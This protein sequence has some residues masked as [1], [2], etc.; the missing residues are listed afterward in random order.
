MTI[1]YT[2]GL[3]RLV[4]D[5]R[6]FFGAH[7][8]TAVVAFGRKEL[9]KQLNQGPG[10]ANRV[11]I[12][13]FDPGSGAG[14][15]LVHPTLGGL[16]DVYQT[17]PEPADVRVGV[18]RALFDWEREMVVSVWA[19]DNTAPEDELAQETALQFLVEKTI[20]AVHE[21]AKAAAE[22]GGISV[23]VPKGERTFGLEARIGLRFTHPLYDVPEDVGYPGF[24]L[25]R[26]V[27]D[28]E[29]DEEG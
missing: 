12:A 25:G 20:Q 16:R 4:A 24:D 22:W 19:Y 11:V 13:P 23:V 6:A 18:A 28:E 2:S 15:R 1:R 5:V 29:P 27:P 17:D 7:G 14:G 9:A 10:G 21:S 26:H 3:A 8:V